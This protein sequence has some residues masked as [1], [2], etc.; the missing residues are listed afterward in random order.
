V[1]Y[2]RSLCTENTLLVFSIKLY[3]SSPLVLSL[4]SL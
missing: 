2:W 3:T 1:F 4:K